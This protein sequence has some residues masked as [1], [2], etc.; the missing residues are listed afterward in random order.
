MQ[1]AEARQL[2][3]SYLAGELQMDASHEVLRHLDLCAACRA[4]VQDRRRLN[5]GLRRAFHRS[6]ELAASPEFTARL[7]DNLRDRASVMQPPVSRRRPFMRWAAAAAACLVAC[8]GLLWAYQAMLGD[9]LIAA[10]VGD[11]SYCALPTDGPL[12]IEATALQQPAYR[13]L[14]AVPQ[15][16]SAVAGSEVLVLDRHVCVYGGRRFVHLVLRH[17]GERL[18]LVVSA[19]R[20]SL[21]AQFGAARVDGMNVVSFRSGPLTLFVVGELSLTDLQAIATLI[22]QQLRQ[23]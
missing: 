15:T 5:E 23:A 12:S 19:D 2:F 17:R 6:P 9:T 7:R 1:C 18:S 20:N 11:H 8:A 10:A 22:D 4:E 21:P 14:E 13:R 3:D 16:M